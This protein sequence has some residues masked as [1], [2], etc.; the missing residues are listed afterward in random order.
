MGTSETK[1]EKRKTYMREWTRKNKEKIAAYRRTTAERRNSQRRERYANNPVL[2]QKARDGAR[3]WQAKNPDKRKAQRIKQYGLTTEEFEA[4]LQEQ[5][6]ACKICGFSDR[7]NPNFFPMVDHCHQTGRVRGLLC[8]NCNH[9][10]GKF[11]DN[12]GLLERAASYLTN[13]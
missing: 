10:L 3:E 4:L 8:G 2:Q 12:P 6:G 7:S 1:S 13:G 9:G 5:G 11:K